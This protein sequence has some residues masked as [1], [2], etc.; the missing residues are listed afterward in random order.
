MPMCSAPRAS[1][2]RLVPSRAEQVSTTLTISRTRV[3][4]E[5]VMEQRHVKNLERF[6]EEVRKSVEQTCQWHKKL[7]KTAIRAA[8]AG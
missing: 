1:D 5:F 6:A 4:E 7:S 2:R 8:I 3:G